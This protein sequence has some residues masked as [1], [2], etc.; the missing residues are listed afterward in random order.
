M[1]WKDAILTRLQPPAGQ[2]GGAHENVISTK[3]N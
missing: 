2:D 1:F 3:V